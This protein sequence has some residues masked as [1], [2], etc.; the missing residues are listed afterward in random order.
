M[1]LFLNQG[2]LFVSW[3][4]QVNIVGFKWFTAGLRNVQFFSRDLEQLLSNLLVKFVSKYISL[5][6]CICNAGKIE[7]NLKTEH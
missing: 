6:G 7:Q 1:M 2:L 5:P 3:E 4:L